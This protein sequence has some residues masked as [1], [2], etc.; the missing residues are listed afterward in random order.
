METPVSTPTPAA[1]PAKSCATCRW[2]DPTMYGTQGPPYEED[3]IAACEWPAERLP[4][5]LRYGNRERVAVKPTDGADCSCYELK[6]PQTN[7]DKDSK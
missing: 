2:F 1:A 7:I 4:F 6:T 5:S 3:D